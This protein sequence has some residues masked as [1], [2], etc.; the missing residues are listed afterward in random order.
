MHYTYLKV[1]KYQKLETIFV[2]TNEYVDIEY[3][4]L[5]KWYRPALL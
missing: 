2:I 4:Y 3:L 1:L 5:S